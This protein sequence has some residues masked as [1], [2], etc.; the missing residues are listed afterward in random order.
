MYIP[1][2][3]ACNTVLAL[4]YFGCCASRSFTDPLKGCWV[5]VVGLMMNSWGIGEGI[6]SS[7]LWGSVF[8]VMNL[9]L[10]LVKE[11][12]TNSILE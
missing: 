7:V 4:L 12:P 5:P 6:S 3:P 9:P 8:T 11:V 2:G 1:N 10:W